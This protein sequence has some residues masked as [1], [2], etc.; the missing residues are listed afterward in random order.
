MQELKFDSIE[1]EFRYE[2]SRNRSYEMLVQMALDE[3]R[4]SPRNRDSA[5]AAIAGNHGA[6]DQADALATGGDAKGALALLEV[7]T[8]RLIAMLRSAGFPIP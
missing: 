6:R 2:R 8:G 3:Q 7:S 1:D 5:V 4:V